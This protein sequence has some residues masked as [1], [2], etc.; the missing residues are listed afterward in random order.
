MLASIGKPREAVRSALVHLIFN[1]GGVCL[2]F[3]FVPQLSSLACAISPASAEAVGTATPRQ[4]A[5]AHAIFNIGNTLIFIWFTTPLAWLVTRLVPD[6]ARAERPV[7]EPRYLNEYVLQTPALAMDFGRMELG[8][9]GKLVLAMVHRVLPTITQGTRA[10]LQDLERQD[11]NVDALY[12]E[13]VTYLGRLAQ[14]NLTDEQSE[15]LHRYLAA[16]NYL[17]NIGDMIETNLVDVGRERSRLGLSISAKTQSV[18]EALDRRVSWSVGRAVDA[19]AENNLRFA[20]EVT[21]SKTEFAHLAREA[22]K[23]LSRRLSADEPNRLAAF[24]L[25]SEILEYLKRMYYFSKRIAKLVDGD[26][27]LAEEKKG[28]ETTPS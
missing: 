22:E 27:S 8:R 4:I 25:E 10:E 14:E 26:G 3:A 5:N 15:Q 1:V 17:E 12:G 20:Q 11:D 16:A 21:Q 18:L 28:D 23:H 13:I 2:W 9:L 6:R 7:A 24:R 19:L